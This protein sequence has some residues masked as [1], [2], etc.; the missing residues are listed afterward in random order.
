[1]SAANLNSVFDEVVDKPDD[2]VA[3]ESGVEMLA[4]CGWSYAQKICPH[5]LQFYR[6]ERMRM[7]QNEEKVTNVVDLNGL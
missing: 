5:F 7:K 1:M 3:D 2:E 4:I 6:F